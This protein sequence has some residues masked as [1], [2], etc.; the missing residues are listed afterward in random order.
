[1]TQ[2][3]SLLN[4]HGVAVEGPILLTPSLNYDE[5]GFFVES[6]NHIEFNS[7][8]GDRI[9]FLLDGHSFSKKGVLRGM[10]YQIPPNQQG[11]LVRCI[12]GEIYDVIV[13]LRKDSPTFSS[14]IATN[15]SNKNF[16]QLWVPPG[17]A[18]GFLTLSDTSEVLY[19][20][21]DVWHPES[22]R[23]IRWN[24]RTIS[25]KWPK[26]NNNPEVSAKDSKASS[27]DE[28]KEIDLF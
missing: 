8:I 20:L 16:Y 4:N 18:H 22:E 11:K 28:L 26:V 10:H 1:V 27:F 9:N 21:T 3:K 13:D 24:D 7:L 25:I 2:I 15:I 6:W 19:K 14:W 12:V 5:R 17:F 23:S